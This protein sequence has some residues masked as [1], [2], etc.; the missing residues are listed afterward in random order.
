MSFAAP[1]LLALLGLL[2]L[3][4]W[5]LRAT[6][7]APR[8]ESFPPIRLLFGLRAAEETPARTPLWLLALRLLAA[9]LL[10]LGLAGPV[11]HP[12]PLLSGSG[13][14]LLVIDNSWAAAPD[15][16]ARM[17]AANRL[18]ARAAR[19]HRSAALLATARGVDDRPP[20]LTLAMPAALLR[21]R[22]AALR[23]MPWPPDRAAAAAALRAWHGRGP[24]I[25]LAD[26]LTE[27]PGFARFAAA[28]AAGPLHEIL[29]STP[30]VLL[31]PPRRAGERLIARLATTPAPL[32][33]R[34]VILAESGHRRALAR[35][36][37]VIPAGA[38]MAEAPIDLPLALRNRLD[39][40]VLAGPPAASAVVLLDRRYR[41]RLVGLASA[42]PARAMTPLAGDLYFI[43]R[44]L[45]PS[46]SLI[47][48][49]VPQLLARH[50]AVI[51]L[52]DD[53][54]AAG[55]GRAA[56]AAWVSRGGLLV[57]FAGPLLA[58]HPDPLLPVKLLPGER[59][60]GGTLTWRQPLGLA[61][62]PPA[63]PFAG[64]RLPTDIRVS[65]ELLADPARLGPGAVW[66]RLADGTPLATAASFGRGRIV[67]IHVSANAAW[68]NLPL[69]GLFPKMLA[70]L[71]ALSSGRP[72]AS[73]AAVLAPAET[74][75]GFGTLRAPPP[76]AIGLTAAAFRQVRISPRHPPGLYGPAG[77]RLALSLGAGIAP[78][79]AAPAIAGARVSHLGRPAPERDLGPPLV[80]AALLLLVLDLIASLALRGLFRPSGVAVSAILLALATGPAAE[81][82]P[83]TAGPAEVPKAALVDRLAYVVTGVAGV[84]ALSRA[85]L[86]GLVR[87]VDA[88]TSAL[89]AAPKGVRPGHSDLSLYPLLYWPITASTPATSAPAVAALNAFMGHGGILFIDTEGGDVAGNGSGAGF[90]P[91][92]GAALRRATR[93]LDIPPLAPL[94]PAHVLAHS[95]YLLRA[96]PGRFAGAR[97]WVARQ[98]VRANDN[99]SP[100]II[101]ANDWLAAWARRPG[102]GYL[103]AT[104]PGGTWQRTL[105]FRFGVNL[106]MYAL[107][108]T[109]KADQIH[110]P[111]ILQRLGR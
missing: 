58:A 49:S 53:P 4:W 102:G 107:T 91:G 59:R 111:A 50:P 42:D 5:L 20:A 3:L 110:V 62:F 92:V 14:I 96:F 12:P 2:P 45:A 30:P 100:V 93:G 78:P 64:L 46:A 71:V 19:D 82:A 21:P 104:L 54:V 22:L 47:T 44:A 26:G 33:R 81:A 80:A 75:D 68:S 94:T 56:L 85:G 52:A 76:A 98:G 105:A 67:L 37:L 16:S 84:D 108:G 69:S 66:A 11:L 95:F 41:R 48:G 89:L 103:Y 8:R 63:S 9:A 65:R 35:L 90:A 27:G 36:A 39:R 106:V 18:L 43:H 55:P 77:A 32:P 101:G 6:P 83:A 70:R 38:T 15:W 24:V 29:A 51:I 23:P 7:P 34:A 109:Y 25:Y 86:S 97:V 40:L 10:I 28:L 73:G 13:P 31:L 1:W 79:R 88:R 74:M 99:V 17:A 87:F 72:P 61:P 57:R 60:L